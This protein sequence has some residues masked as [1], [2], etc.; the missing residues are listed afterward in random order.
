MSNEKKL[1]V[2]DLSVKELKAMVYDESV[3][4]EGIRNNIRLLVEAIQ[5][6]QKNKEIIKD[7]NSK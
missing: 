4:I 6:K 7:E 3:R 1:H 2:D 5:K